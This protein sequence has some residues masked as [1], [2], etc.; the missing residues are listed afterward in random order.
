[1]LVLPVPVGFIV[2]TDEGVELVPFDSL[3]PKD[4][5][6]KIISLEEGNIIPEYQRIREK[7]KERIVSIPYLVDIGLADEAIKADREMFNLISIAEKKA[8]ELLGSEEKYKEFMR[9]LAIELLKLRL[10]KELSRKDVIVVQL[11]KL[12]DSLEKIVNQLA[13]QLREIYGAHFPALSPKTEMGDRID[14]KKYLRIIAEIG[15]ATSMTVEKL[16]PI[17]GEELAKEVVEA[18]RIGPIVLF[19]DETMELLRKIARIGVELFEA[20]EDTKK[21]I[22]DLVEEVAPNVAHLVGDVIAAR[23]IYL[24]KGLER[25]AKMPGSKI[26]VLGAEKALFRSLHK[27][28]PPPKHGVIFRH[29]RINRS[30]KAVRGKIARS[31]AA[32][33]AIAARVDAYSGKFIA[34][35]LKKQLEERYKRVLERYKEALASGLIKKRKEK[36]KPKLKPSKR[37]RK[38]ERKGEKKGK[39][40]RKR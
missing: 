20:I 4:V 10:S 39:K 16:A 29:P 3:D 34:D 15:P 6:R 38:K 28:T 32:K 2:K 36:R 11:V 1:M 9:Q 24:A 7:A 8:I 37:E 17:V 33:I 31:M 26:Q 25:L 40:R 12:L 14:N 22:S 27:G 5:A 35:T 13:N 19:D 23:L 21:R 18:A 30:P